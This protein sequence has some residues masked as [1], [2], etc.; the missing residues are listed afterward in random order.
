LLDNVKVLANSEYNKLL[1]KIN[2]LAMLSDEVVPQLVVDSFGYVDDY[3]VFSGII[4]AS[5]MGAFTENKWQFSEKYQIL[6]TLIPTLGNT[7]ECTAN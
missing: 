3:S 6:D 5:N 2:E 4:G 1:E 7:Y